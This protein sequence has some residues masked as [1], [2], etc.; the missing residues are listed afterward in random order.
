MLTLFGPVPENQCVREMR[1]QG[2][3]A[4]HRVLL[5]MVPWTA[6]RVD[7]VSSFGDVKLLDVQLN[8]LRRPYTDGVLCIGDAAHAMSPVGGAASTWRWPTPSPPRGYW[9][10]R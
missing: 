2:I 10:T 6:D 4:F 5:G 9:P 8:R 3:E 1:S 7:T